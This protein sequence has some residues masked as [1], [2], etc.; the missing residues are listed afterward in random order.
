MSFNFTKRT[1]LFG[2][3]FA[4]FQLTYRYSDSNVEQRTIIH[5]FQEVFKDSSF[6]ESNVRF[7]RFVSATSPEK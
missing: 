1:N 6:S 5:I 2:V 7:N 3:F 4:F